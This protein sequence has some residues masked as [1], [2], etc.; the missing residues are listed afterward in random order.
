MFITDE[1]SSPQAA[2]AIYEAGSRKQEAGSRKCLL[3]PFLSISHHW[4][5]VID[6]MRNIRDILTRILHMCLY[7]LTRI[8][9]SYGRSV[10]AYEYMNTVARRRRTNFEFKA[11]QKKDHYGF[12]LRKI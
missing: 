12:G 5:L 3:N 9:R 8:I 1:N 4:N 10:S 11:A 6:P 7:G 2:A